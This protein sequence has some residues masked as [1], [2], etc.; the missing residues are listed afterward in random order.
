MIAN[1]RQIVNRAQEVVYPQLLDRLA[2]SAPQPQP[3]PAASSVIPG[4]PGD[5]VESPSPVPAAPAKRNVHIKSIPL[6]HTATILE[7]ETDIDAFL[8]AYRSRLVA[9]LEQGERILL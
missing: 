7:S 6:P 3:Q 2:A 8:E 9:A 1:I 5:V 4:D